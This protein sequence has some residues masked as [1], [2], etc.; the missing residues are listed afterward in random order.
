MARVAFFSSGQG[1]SPLTL[2]NIHCGPFYEETHG[3]PGL[4]PPTLMMAGLE[5][6]KAKGIN[7]D[8]LCVIDD[9]IGDKPLSERL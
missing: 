7:Y 9:Y 2:K 8:S 3:S 5:N 1:D 6:T 4:R